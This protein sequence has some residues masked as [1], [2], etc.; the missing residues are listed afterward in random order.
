M[1]T[2]LD[3]VS[4]LPAGHDQGMLGWKAM[5]AFNISL[6]GPMNA[7]IVADFVASTRQEKPSAPRFWGSFWTAVSVTSGQEASAVA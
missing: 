3:S 4:H 6:P 7:D 5:G 2:P 1:N